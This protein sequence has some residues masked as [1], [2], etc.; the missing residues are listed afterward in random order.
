MGLASVGD[1]KAVP[2]E[3]EDRGEAFSGSTQAAGK[4]DDE[5]GAAEAGDTAREPRVGI[6]GGAE[7]A[8][9]FSEAGGFAIDDAA[10]GFRRAVA[11]AEAGAADGEDEGGAPVAQLL[12]HGCD[13]VF[14]VGEK[15]GLELSIGVGLAEQLDDG[16]AGSVS[17]QTPRAAVGDGEDGEEHGDDCRGWGTGVTSLVLEGA[18]RSERRSGWIFGRR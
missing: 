14:V 3:I 10:G 9:G 4:V 18:G 16:R 15:G 11:G 17:E 13:G 8:Y 2:N 1:V 6:G 7:R 12:E 5:C